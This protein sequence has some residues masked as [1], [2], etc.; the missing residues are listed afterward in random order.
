M[1]IKN[2]R[3]VCGYYLL[4]RLLSSFV[5]VH[6]WWTSYLCL[7]CAY[8]LF[9]CFG[10]QFVIQLSWALDY[11]DWR[12]LGRCCSWKTLQV[13]FIKNKSISMEETK[14]YYTINYLLI[15]LQLKK[16]HFFFLSRTEPWLKTRKRVTI[17]EER[18]NLS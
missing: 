6:C 17:L 13:T 4:L 12:S 16:A 2:S 8:L 7:E 3:L 1:K 11:E 18:W 14:K 10:F 9:S 5:Y 15:H